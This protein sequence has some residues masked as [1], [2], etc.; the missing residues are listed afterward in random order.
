MK[1]RPG[2]EISSRPLHF[3]WIADCSGSMSIDGKMQALNTAIREVIPHMRKVADEN[4]NAQVLVR[5]IKFSSGAQW[6]ISQPT[7]V[8]DFNWTDLKADGVTDLGK[9]L[10]MVAEEMKMPPMSD[11]ALPPV[12][13]LVSDGQPTD[14]YSKG[15]SE[16]MDQPWGKKAVRIAIAIGEDVDEQVLEKFIGH[17]E[18]KPLKA[19]NPEAL[20]KHIKWVSTA[21]L[22]SASAPASQSDE[23]SGNYTNVPIPVPS[24]NASISSTDVW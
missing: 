12:L 10:S 13:V 8:E 22:K 16:L 2:G 3:I 24:N 1:R 17:P 14:E 5:A 19:N 20:L 18:L 15:L 7:P 21:V 23:N 9:A 6:H 4:P 11:R